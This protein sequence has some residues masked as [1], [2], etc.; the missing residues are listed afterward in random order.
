M[1]RAAPIV[2]GKPTAIGISITAGL[3]PR[4]LLRKE[5]FQTS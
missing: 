5:L 3:I 4:R 2:N 1:P